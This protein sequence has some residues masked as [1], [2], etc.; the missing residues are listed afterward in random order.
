MEFSGSP[1]VDQE[2]EGAAAAGLRLFVDGGEVGLDGP[3]GGL[4]LGAGIERLQHIL[5]A[6]RSDISV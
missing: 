2:G 6:S 1:P 4:H 5:S 3:F